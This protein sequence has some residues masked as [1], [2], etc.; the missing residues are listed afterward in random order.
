MAQFD[1][2][3]QFIIER[4]SLIR[5]LNI[6]VTLPQGPDLFNPLLQSLL[7]SEDRPYSIIRDCM[8]LTKVDSTF[9]IPFGFNSF[10]IF[11]STVFYRI[12]LTGDECLNRGIS[13]FMAIP[14]LRPKTSKSRRELQPSRF[15]P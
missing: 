13:S 8:A 1:R 9:S 3:H 6:F 2:L 15:A 14:L 4:L 7:I 5:N 12:G 11:S 10:S